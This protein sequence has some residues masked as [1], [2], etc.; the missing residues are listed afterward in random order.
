MIEAWFPIDPAPLTKNARKRCSC[1]GGRPSSYTKPESAQAFAEFTMR[2]RIAWCGESFPVYPSGPVVIEIDVT[3][4]RV[5][6]K[7][8]AKGLAFMDDDAP[9]E[10]VR[11]ALQGIAYTADAQCKRTISEKFTVDEGPVGIRVRIY[12]PEEQQ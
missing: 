11:D 9:V 2:A 5:H 3:P 6:A 10:A 12:R 7:G 1:R 4:K 8:C